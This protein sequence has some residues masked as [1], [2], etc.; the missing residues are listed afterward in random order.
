[1][2]IAAAMAA[3]ASLNDVHRPVP[4]DTAALGSAAKCDPRRALQKPPVRPS[5]IGLDAAAK[6]TDWLSA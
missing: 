3:A 5:M 4:D 1:M 6:G 2:R